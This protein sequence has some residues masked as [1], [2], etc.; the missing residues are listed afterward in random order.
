MPVVAIGDFAVCQDTS[1]DWDRSKSD[2]P[3]SQRKNQTVHF[4]DDVNGGIPR[5]LGLVYKDP[6]PPVLSW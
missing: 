6:R 2:Q 1:H 5:G 4:S 3:Q